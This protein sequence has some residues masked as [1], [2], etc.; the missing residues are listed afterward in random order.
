MLR[1]FSGG[2]QI[3]LAETADG[4]RG[5]IGINFLGSSESLV[6]G[7]EVLS[8]MISNYSTSA[9]FKASQYT[10]GAVMEAIK[11]N[12]VGFPPGWKVPS[13]FTDARDLFVG[14]LELAR[15]RS[16]LLSK[17]SRTNRTVLKTRK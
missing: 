12:F 11:N 13:S 2:G 1:K 6:H 14:Y 7:N 15:M 8:G 17:L 9:K 5:V 3:K 16:R 4:Y 10:I